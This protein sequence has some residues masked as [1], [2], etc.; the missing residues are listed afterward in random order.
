MAGG[1]CGDT[2]GAVIEA[3]SRLIG[4]WIVYRNRYGPAGTSRVFTHTAETWEPDIK[5]S[6]GTS[7][8]SQVFSRFCPLPVFNGAYTQSGPGTLGMLL[9]L[10]F[11]FAHGP[12]NGANVMHV[13]HSRAQVN[14]AQTPLEAEWTW[15]VCNA[16]MRSVRTRVQ[17]EEFYRRLTG[18]LL[19]R[20]PEPAHDV[21]EIYD[22]AYHRPS[23]DYQRVYNQAKQMLTGIGLEFD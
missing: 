17:G 22:W 7:L 8:V 21:R 18:L 13:R 9:E 12:I 23:E 14:H 16:V 10:A 15:Q 2:E 11:N 5:A 4:G 20:A 1:F 6:W 3:I 19:G